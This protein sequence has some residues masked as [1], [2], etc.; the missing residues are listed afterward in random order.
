M[1]PTIAASA[2][3]MQTKSPTAGRMGHSKW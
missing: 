1:R 3:I 2:A